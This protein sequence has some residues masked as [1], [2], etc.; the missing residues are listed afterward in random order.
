MEGLGNTVAGD[1]DIICIVG[2]QS[3]VLER[4]REEVYYRESE[5]LFGVGERLYGVS[6]FRGGNK[7]ID[8]YHFERSGGSLCRWEL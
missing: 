2:G 1:L 5:S 7:L 8:C 3:A 4:G 6:K